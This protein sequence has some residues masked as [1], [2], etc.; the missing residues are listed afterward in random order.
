[1]DLFFLD[2]ANFGLKMVCGVPE[3]KPSGA[4]LPSNAH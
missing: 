1:M 3:M 4:N 2:E